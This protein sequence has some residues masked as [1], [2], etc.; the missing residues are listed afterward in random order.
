MKAYGVPKSENLIN[1]KPIYPNIQQQSQQLNTGGSV[2]GG[3]NNNV[4]ASGS[5]YGVSSV[6]IIH[7]IIIYLHFKIVYN[8]QYNI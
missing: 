1:N 8:W 3:T 2:Y 5:T 6:S 4:G 7:I